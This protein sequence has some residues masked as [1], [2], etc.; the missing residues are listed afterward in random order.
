MRQFHLN[1]KVVH[2][3][4]NLDVGYRDHV[5]LL[6]KNFDKLPES[7]K[8]DGYFYLQ[9]LS[10]VPK[11]SKQPWFAHLYLLEKTSCHQW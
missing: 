8:V 6:D 7:I 3:Y 4:Q 5:Y 1:N 10:K 9:P 2:Q 11:D